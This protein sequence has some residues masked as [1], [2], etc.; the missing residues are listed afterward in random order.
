[1]TC[2][3]S[4]ESSNLGYVY[5]FLI[6]SLYSYVYVCFQSHWDDIRSPKR[7]ICYGAKAAPYMNEKILKKICFH[8]KQRNEFQNVISA[9]AAWTASVV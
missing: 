9:T 8:W 3:V 6:L 2:Y 4:N 7:R 5:F 1:M